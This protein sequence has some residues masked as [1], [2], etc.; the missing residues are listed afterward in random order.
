M[1]RLVKNRHRGRHRGSMAAAY[2]AMGAALVLAVA[3][4]P[5]AAWAQ[6]KK[7]AGPTADRESTV[8]TPND[9]RPQGSQGEITGSLA[10][11]KT[12]K[13][14]PEDVVI[15]Q[16]WREPELSGEAVVR[17]DGKISLSL[18]GDVDVVGLTPLEVQEKVKVELGKVMNNPVVSV[19]MRA[20]RSSKYYITGNAARS[21]MFPLVVPTTVLEALTLAG[22]LT[23]WANKKKIVILRGKERM[24]FNYN[25][26]IKGKKLEQNILLQ[27]GDFIIID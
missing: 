11:P 15:I 4:S 26:V 2:C 17:P 7:D 25:D 9:L 24:Y 13:I 6:A 21:G 19:K 8:Q 12:F 14:G 5:E 27:N 22:G 18:V 16:V 3:G 20:I 23:E 10:D 1:N